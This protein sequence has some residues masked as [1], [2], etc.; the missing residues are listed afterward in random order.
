VS[1]DIAN[2]FGNVADDLSVIMLDPEMKE[3]RPFE[4]SAISDVTTHTDMAEGFYFPI[5]LCFLKVRK[6]MSEAK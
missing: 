6:V 4:T 2:D 1:C 3:F 5:L